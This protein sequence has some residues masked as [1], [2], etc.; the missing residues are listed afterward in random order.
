MPS[1]PSRPSLPDGEPW[2][3]VRRLAEDSARALEAADVVGRT[4]EEARERVEAAGLRLRPVRPG[5]M[6]TADWQATRVTAQ[7][8]DGVVREA[9]IG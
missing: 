2:D 8:G 5:D 6:V 9:R 7:V 3:G 1:T 4:V